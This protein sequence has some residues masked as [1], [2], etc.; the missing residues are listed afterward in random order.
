MRRR[1]LLRRPRPGGKIPNPA[2][3]WAPAFAGATRKERPPNRSIP[4]VS[5]LADVIPFY[6]RGAGGG[7]PGHTPNGQTSCIAGERRSESRKGDSCA[8]RGARA[9]NKSSQAAGFLCR[10]AVWLA[11]LGI[12]CMLLAGAARAADTAGRSTIVVFGDSQAAGI[13]AGL[14][15]VAVDDPRYRILNRTHAG[16]AIVHGESEWLAPI[17]A[18]LS[19]DRDKADVAVVMFGAND[20]LDMRD[21]D[22]TFLRFRTEEW[23][24][25]YARRADSILSSLVDAGLKF[26]WCGNPIARS[27]T[28]SSDMGYINQILATEAERFGGQFVP[29]WQVITDDRGG[30]TGYAKDRDGV[31]RRMR[32]DDG[33]HFTAAGYEVIA[34]RI[35]EL[36]PPANAPVP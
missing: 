20:R 35:I 7:K 26:I 32:A 15:R 6:P 31:T 29:L 25:V 4:R 33:I 10:R 11:G 27:E 30:Y 18:F 13:A 19:R 17:R 21:T 22:G 36:L 16:A 14:Q 28:Y 23:R 24:D 3:P 9:V 34:D 5:A 12:A 1:L 2:L 8:F